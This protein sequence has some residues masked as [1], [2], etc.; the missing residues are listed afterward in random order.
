[1]RTLDIDGLDKPLTRLVLGTDWWKPERLDEIAPVAD[2]FAELGGRAVDTSHVYQRGQSERAVGQWLA[3]S[4]R[5]D[6]FVIL[7]KGC[8]PFTHGRPRVTPENIDADLAGSLDRLGVDFIDLY[9]LH[10]DDPNVP[11]GPIV[12]RL[13]HHAEAGRIG[14]FGGSNWTVQRLAE[15]NEY[16]AGHGLRPFAVSSPNLTLATPNEAMWSDCLTLTPEDRVWHE[17][18]RLP[19]LSWSSQ[20]RG[21]FSGRFTPANTEPGEDVA[22]V[23]F[24]DEN[25]ARLDRCRE[26]GQRKGR[27]PIQIALAWV[28]A[29]P[30]ATAALVGPHSPAEAESCAAA[31]AIDLTADEVKWLEQGGQTD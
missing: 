25:W 19:V 11:V 20:A 14:A 6:E 7:T 15:A 12:E 26:L 3:E 10:R 31:A 22:R 4:G 9:L 21:F 18:S 29:Q 27:E 16:A 13:N 2:R 23:F 24:N 28:L 30:F 8:H 5:R 1:M 17:R